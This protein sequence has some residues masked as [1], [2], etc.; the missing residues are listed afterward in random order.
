VL[1]GVNNR[2]GLLLTTIAKLGTLY[3]LM[4][5]GWVNWLYI[6]LVCGALVSLL[7]LLSELRV[8]RFIGYSGLV[9]DVLLLF[10]LSLSVDR[11]TLYLYLIT[12][13]FNIWLVW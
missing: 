9:S 8:G 12:Y 1:T 7:G 2:Q 4:V 3:L 5:L 13:F 6:V 10:S 11:M